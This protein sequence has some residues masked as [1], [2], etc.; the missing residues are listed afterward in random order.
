MSKVE[1]P[2]PPRHRNHANVSMTSSA[3]VGHI[4]SWRIIRIIMA[5]SNARREISIKHYCHLVVIGGVAA[6]SACSARIKAYFY[7]IAGD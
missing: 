7:V 4:S 2:W 5:I 1:A 3:Y 6:V